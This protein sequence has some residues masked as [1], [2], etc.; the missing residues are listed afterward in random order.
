MLPS[1]GEERQPTNQNPLRGL[2]N[3]G[4]RQG[5]VNISVL[6]TS[7]SRTTD[8]DVEKMGPLCAVGGNVRWCK[9][10]GEQYIFKKLKTRNTTWPIDSLLDMYPK[11]LEAESQRD[12]C[13]P[14]LFTTAK[15]WKQPQCPVMD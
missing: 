6:N 11:E 2:D 10:Y 7:A 12:I 4:E 14:A 3:V 13:T 9:C 8:E 15:K 1:S 5:T